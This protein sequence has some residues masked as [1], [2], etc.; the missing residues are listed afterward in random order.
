[1]LR[2]TNRGLIAF[3]ALCGLALFSVVISADQPATLFAAGRLIEGLVVMF[4]VMTAP[5]EREARIAFIMGAFVQTGIA[6]AELAFQRVYPNAWLGIAAHFPENA[7]TSVVEAA[8][9]RLLRAY[10]TLPHPN[11]LGG[12]LVIAILCVR[13]TLRRVSWLGIAAYFFLGLGLFLTFS[14]LA[15]IALIAGI[16]VQWI[17]ARR[18]RIFTRQAPFAFAAL[19]LAAALF[20]PFVAARTGTI[21]RLEAK[22]IAA[23]V[24]SYR[25]A[26]ALVAKHPFTGVGAGAFT[27]T[28][29]EQVDPKRSGYE[30]EPAHSAPLEVLAEIGVFGFLLYLWF[31]FVA[32]R[33]AWKSGRPGMAAAL[34]CLAALDHWSW[35]T[36]AGIVI[37]FLGWGFTIRGCREEGIT[38]K[39]GAVII[40]HDDPGKI[41]LLYRAGEDYSDW[42]LPKGHMEPG[43]SREDTMKRE[44]KEETGLDVKILG[45]LP[46]RHYNAVKGKPVV[47]HF[48]LA[49]SLDDAKLR[50]ES[51]YPGNKL[52]WVAIE[53]AE[54]RL[55]FDNMKKYFR[56]I[57]D[58]IKGTGPLS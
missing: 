30:L 23:R 29:H 44:V 38:H 21:G 54:S 47:A 42:T 45:F 17:Y 50:L 26:L 2:S 11:I 18:D 7:G 57:R 16:A 32:T 8:G 19:A 1:M 36:Y 43:E 9:M 41:L 3:A 31:L 33:L 10:G 40:S 6:I 5:S 22:S 20:W 35:T 48:F 13:S 56:S 46:D 55:T 53:E 4:L 28:V 39:S 12:Y 27:A 52:E 15:W 14:R 49:R 25:D 34:I 51:G 24:S 37:F 58:S